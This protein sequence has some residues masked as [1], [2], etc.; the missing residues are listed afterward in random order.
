MAPIKQNHTVHTSARFRCSFAANVN[1]LS[2]TRV[3]YMNKA[4]LQVR[5]LCEWEEAVGQHCTAQRGGGG[6]TQLEGLIVEY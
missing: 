6:V 2:S 4:V 3:L 5:N 1:E